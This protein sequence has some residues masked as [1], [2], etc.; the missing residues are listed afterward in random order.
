M[1]GNTLLTKGRMHRSIHHRCGY[2]S[3][4]NWVLLTL[5]SLLWGGSFFFN[6]LALPMGSSMVIVLG[7]VGIG[8]LGL[9]A[10]LSWRG[11][12]MPSDKKLWAGFVFMGLF[13]N[14]LP[15][16]LFV[17]A[18][19]TLDAG[20]TATLNA[21]T[22]LFAAL[23][24]H[25]F[26]QDERLKT[27]VVV[28]IGIAAVGVW[29][30][31]GAP[32]LAGD[33]VYA[34]WMPLL[35]AVFYGCAAVFAKRMGKV[36][37]EVAA[38]GM[39]TCSTIMSLLLVTVMGDWQTIELS[40]TP[41]LAVLGLGLASTSL[42]Y[43]LYFKIINSAGATALSLVTVLIPLSATALG[44]L[45]LDDPLSASALAGMACIAFSLLVFNGWI[46]LPGGKN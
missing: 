35:A 21:T 29:V 4:S 42:A 26:T 39:L 31:T 12:K 14:L 36:Q 18:Q 5:L 33:A 2:M 34:I 7:R 41:V 38:T 9:W 15:F 45:F 40:M 22:P 24:A 13:N 6:E 1:G 32:S 10:L 23:L 30:L 44:V 28:A 11:I 19:R 8:A 20:M 27:R 16:L 25:A 46:R 43:L 17:Q 3:A 37:P